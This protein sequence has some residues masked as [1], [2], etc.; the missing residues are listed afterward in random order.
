MLVTYEITC[1]K[2]LAADQIAVAKPFLQYTASDAGQGI[3]EGIGY[4][5]ITG[6]L[7]TKVKSSVEALS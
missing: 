4:V 7:L 2:G 5:P 6:E 3:L 1:S